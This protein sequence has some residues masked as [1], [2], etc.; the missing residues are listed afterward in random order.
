[1]SQSSFFTQDLE[2]YSD[3]SDT[4]SESSTYNS[5]DDDQDFYHDITDVL[6]FE[7]NEQYTVEIEGLIYNY[8]AVIHKQ[9]P[10]ANALQISI[11]CVCLQNSYNQFWIETTLEDDK[12]TDISILKRALY[13]PD[14]LNDS[15]A[16]YIQFYN[17]D[18]CKE[19][20][21]LVYELAADY[22]IPKLVENM[23]WRV[24]AHDVL[25]E[26]VPSDISHHILQCN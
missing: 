2:L 17:F 5:I 22:V 20:E 4:D 9:Y 10:H 7:N 25:C 3:I 14:N 23:F 13:I 26:L 21:Q 19:I 1:M 24:C 12:Y 15:Q 16:E 6:S 18:H 11:L 8:N